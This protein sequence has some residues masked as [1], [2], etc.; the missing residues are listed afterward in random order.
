VELKK[1]ATE[2]FSS[3]H[4]MHGENTLSRAHVLIGTRDF[5]KEERVW[6]MINC[7]DGFL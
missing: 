2:M 3:L 1:T 7:A 4:E 5:Q 6:E